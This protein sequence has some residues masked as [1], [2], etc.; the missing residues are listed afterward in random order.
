MRKERKIDKENIINAV[1][2]LYLN[3]IR[4]N[5]QKITKHEVEIVYNIIK[6]T[7]SEEDI[8]LHQIQKL[9]ENP[10]PLKQAVSVIKSHLFLSDK[11]TLLM[12]LLVIANINEDFS[13]VDR[14][15]ILEVVEMLQI[16]IHQY[17]QI[18]ELIE[19][20][21][22]YFD[23]KLE[24][25][26]ENLSQTMFTNFLVFGE[27]PDCDLRFKQDIST[28]YNLIIFIIEELILIGSFVNQK[29]RI[30]SYILE[31]DKLYKLE[32]GEVLNLSYP[33]DISSLQI[34]Y[35]D[36]LKLYF[37]KKNHIT[38]IIKY[39]KES[40]DLDILQENN[41][42]QVQVYDGNIA[43]N[44]KNLSHNNKYELAINDSIVI[45]EVLKFS[46]LDILT[47][48]LLFSREERKFETLYIDSAE[49]F[50]R[51]SE[52]KSV[53]S[54]AK[55]SRQHDN[56]TIFPLNKSIPI[57]LN[58]RLLDQEEEFE[59]PKDIISVGQTNF[60]INKFFDIVKIDYETSKFT[61][62]N[63]HYIFPERSFLNRKKEQIVGLDEISFDVNKGEILAILGP[64]G[65]GKT[66]LL[67]CLNGDIIPDEARIEIDDYDL[68][69]NF[70]HFQKYIGY[71]PQDDL[72]FNSLTVYENLYYCGRLRLPYI[73]DPEDIK[74]KIDNILIQIGLYD[75]KN[76]V[77]GTIMDKKLSG[78]ERKRLNIALELLSDPLIVILDEPTSG[79]SSKDSEK[80]I[81]MLTDLKEQG[82]IL[83]ATIHQPNPDIFQQFDKVLLIDKN[84]TE[85][86][87]GNTNEV[88]HYF[89]DELEQISYGIGNLLRKKELK[90]PEYLF[91]VLQYPLLDSSG[92]PI[93]KK[94]GSAS[95]LDDEQRKYP[96]EYWKTKFKKFQLL[97][98]ITKKSA[99]KE[100][101]RQERQTRKLSLSKA[102][103]SIKE[104][105]SQLYYLFI[106][107]LKNKLMNRTNLFVTFF[108]TPV[109]ALL[110]SFILRYSESGFNYNFAANVNLKLFI[111]ISVIIFIFLGLSN[112]VDEIISEKR[113][114]L[115]EKKLNIKP[116]YFL[117][118]KNITL[119]IF[120]LIQC[121]LYFS[122]SS[123]ILQ[124]QN[125]F[126]IY[127]GYLLLS[128]FIGYSLGLLASAVLK[129]KK[130]IINI[131]PL[132]LIPQIIFG[133]AVIEFE[134]MNRKLKIYSESVIPEFCQFMPS[135]WLF[136]GLFTAQ[137]KLNV[138]KRRITVLN[139][140]EEKLRELRKE[141]KIN[142]E[143]FNKK[144]EAI[145]KKKINI[146]QNYNIKDYVNDD[147]S[148]CVAFIDGKF[149]NSP[150]NY[151]L[152]SKKIY[153][154]KT[155][156][157][158]NTNVLII[159]IYGL[160]IN[161]L[162]FF[163]IQFYFKY[164]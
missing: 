41:Q 26:V 27:S 160:F 24:E 32:K 56:Y 1:V 137:A 22:K 111:F 46:T 104:H 132:V 75:K 115:R 23:M 83:I 34:T 10:Y 99:E 118:V 28:D 47:E 85:V 21:S 35:E 92:N 163:I 109:L 63:L 147:I 135:R 14:L 145:Q 53:N 94:D 81:E 117:I 9:I 82:K 146:L 122:I 44:R 112:S 87:F 7:F 58:H 97:E 119:A 62:Y 125:I 110:I 29:H 155:F 6:S 128:S 31:P 107:N 105:F 2:A 76:L 40:F 60:Q 36:I 106:R 142:N 103:L 91:D 138:Y 49:Q 80:I 141:N 12:N 90:M 150:K 5:T 13:V 48:K 161:L 30:G 108:A 148:M 15:D 86:F 93:S 159:I 120:A 72:L 113:I 65:S 11:L 18:I 153:F 133:G 100:K 64:S 16:D 98:I 102:K 68:Y 71:V 123:I 124:I 78:G 143:K 95:E 131:L 33:S 114:L 3:L 54:I 67:K 25:F 151:F 89:D 19:G 55:I 39:A 66:T 127:I 164:K 61:V 136:E 149:Y 45:N 20:Q 51:I 74:K 17:S 116:V 4:F 130:A 42:I 73:K 129:D 121:V 157:T 37:N 152:S 88:F 101:K 8:H 43:I 126:S 52:M 162:T 50:Y 57:Y 139:L 140:K 38:Q 134:K 156:N 144:K 84:G 70:S 69:E 79:L 77:V 154:G 59:I 96:P 158:Y